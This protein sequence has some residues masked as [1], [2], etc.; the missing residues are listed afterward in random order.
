[1]G[2]L[3]R[4]TQFKDKSAKVTMANGTE[5]IPTGLFMYPVLMAADILLYDADF[6]V[7][8]H[9][10]KQHVELTRDIAIGMNKKYGAKLFKATEPLIPNH[11]SRIMDLAN[12]TIKMSKSNQNETGTIFLNDKPALAVKKIM[13]AKTDSLNKVHFDFVKQPGISNLM[14]I[15]SCLTDTPLTNIENQYKDKSY[16]EFKKDL[17]EIVNKF[18]VSFQTKYKQFAT[19]I[20][21][22]LK[23]L[24]ASAIKCNKIANTKL[25][26]VYKA[27]G[28]RK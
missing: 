5:F 3:R 12:P 28:M 25:D 20:N 9:D 15:Y 16:G 24:S 4:M 11:G 6:V 23:A 13:G 8:G 27:I 1:M 14:T 18:L 26:L 7:V 22:I 17:A 19:E 21:K 10:Q 2:E